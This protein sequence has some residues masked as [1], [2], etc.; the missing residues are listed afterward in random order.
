MSKFEI[1][2]VTMNQTDFSKVK[3]MNIHSDVVFANQADTTQF[4]TYEF[5]NH[6]AKMITTDTKGVGINRNLAIMYSSADIC[7]FADDDITYY[8]DMEEKV[9]S[10]F[11]RHPDADIF[12]FHYDTTDDSRKQRS[13]PK[14]RKCRLLEKMPWGGCRIAVRRKAL[15]QSNIWFTTLFGGGCIFPCG[16]DSLWIADAKRSGMKIYI[17]KETIGILSFETSTWFNPLLKEDYYF[18]QGAG[19]EATFP[20]TALIW[21]LYTVYRLRDNHTLSNKDKLLWMK[22]GRD[23]YKKLLSFD[24]YVKTINKD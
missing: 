17:S 8:D 3:S 10:E 20:K 14:T 18:G 5:E 16:E 7:L 2:C 21:I 12:I 4:E 22:Y 1:L 15:L 9:L 23:G 13:Y 24:E 11:D 19:I 6:I